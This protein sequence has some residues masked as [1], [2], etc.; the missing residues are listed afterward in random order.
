[1]RGQRRKLALVDAEQQDEDRLENQLN[2]K[3]Q[4]RPVRRAEGSID[5]ETQPRVHELR[6]QEDAAPDDH[7]RICG[8]FAR[9]GTT[10]DHDD[11]G[12]DAQERRGQGMAR[13]VYRRLDETD[14]GRLATRLR[15]N[16]GSASVWNGNLPS[17]QSASLDRPPTSAR[18][19]NAGSGISRLNPENAGTIATQVTLYPMR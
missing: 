9:P 8:E 14:L 5:P 3:E 10:S 12:H 1:M 16:L 19:T 6:E 15:W 18:D 7:K 13:R 17:T 4:P 2:R 11:S